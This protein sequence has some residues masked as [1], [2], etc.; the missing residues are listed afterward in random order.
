MNIGIL[1]GTFDP[2][3]IGHLVVAEEVTNRLGLDEVEAS[4]EDVFL[5][6]VRGEEEGGANV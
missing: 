6:L 3:H 1:G 4:L 2:V 5:H